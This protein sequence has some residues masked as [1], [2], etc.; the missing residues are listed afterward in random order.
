MFI[1]EIP[2]EFTILIYSCRTPV[3]CFAW[4]SSRPN[5]ASGSQKI[6]DFLGVALQ[7]QQHAAL[8][9]SLKRA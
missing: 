6:F 7:V 2:E 1:G 5:C 4:V 9:A 8:F 3:S